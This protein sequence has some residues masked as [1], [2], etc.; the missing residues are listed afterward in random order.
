MKKA[1]LLKIYDARPI[2]LLTTVGLDGVPETRP[3]MNIR[4]PNIAPHL[5]PYFQKS[6]RILLITNT[7]TDKVRQ[8][9]ANGRASICVFDEQAFAGLL[10]RGRVRELKDSETKNALWDD[11]W[12]E[13]YP[14]GRDGGDFSVLEFQPDSFKSYGGLAV[15]RG[16]VE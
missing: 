13:Y 8:I 15:T 14:D 1:E 7:S 10:L 2:A 5:T 6:D 4:H 11:S 9:E 16:P 3:L 12:K